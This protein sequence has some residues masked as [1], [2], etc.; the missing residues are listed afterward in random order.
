[1]RNFSPFPFHESL[2]ISIFFYKATFQL[3]L[4]NILRSLFRFSKTAVSIT[5]FTH[6]P[7]ISE[8]MCIKSTE[9]KDIVMMIH[10]LMNR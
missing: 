4:A 2:R 3:P 10:F 6:F 8:E 1:M 7:D 5:I 9:G